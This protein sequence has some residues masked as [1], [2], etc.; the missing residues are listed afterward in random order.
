MSRPAGERL[1]SWI[2]PALSD[3]GADPAEL[4]LAD[5]D[6]LIAQASR[7]G[8]TPLLFRRVL[9]ESKSRPIPRAVVQCIWLDVARQK[10]NTA[11]FERELPTVLQCLQTVGITPILLKG[12][13]LATMVYPEP[14]FRPMG[15][16][17]LLVHAGELAAGEQALCAI[18][19]R[20]PRVESIADIAA[21]ERQLPAMW[22]TGKYLIELHCTL[23]E[24]AARI[25]IDLDGLWSRSQPVTVYGESARVLAPEDALLHICLHGAVL[26]LFENGIRP[27]L[28]VAAILERHG[29]TLD[30]SVVGSR[31]RDWGV[32]RAVYLLL[33]LARR[34]AGVPIAEEILVR[35]DPNGVPAT[36]I[37]AAHAQMFEHSTDYFDD[38]RTRPIVNAWTR[39][40]YFWNYVFGSRADLIRQYRLP[41]DAQHMWWYRIRRVKDLA[42]RYG[43]AAWQGVR[44]DRGLLAT[45]MEKVR[46]ESMLR[47]WLERAQP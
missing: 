18:G 44:H 1:L 42:A 20:S 19:Y 25:Q 33:E 38:V 45:A 11:R 14:L 35:L 28:D 32:E 37:D 9:A 5:W 30:W 46:R 22:Q 39:P 31:A 40:R 34:D 4:S 43:G 3:H 6:E 36:V 47:G 21:N 16:F 13:H 12:A 26:H 24:A 29:T 7:H 8:V 10:A 15:D 2:S 23:A 27:L 41:E 17:D